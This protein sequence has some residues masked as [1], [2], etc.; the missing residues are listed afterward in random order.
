MPGMRGVK[1]TRGG[2]AFRLAGRAAVFALVGAAATVLVA[3]GCFA[4]R[5][6][7]ENARVRHIRKVWPHTT[8]AEWPP[9]PSE[10][11]VYEFPSTLVFTDTEHRGYPTM[12]F[13]RC[14]DAGWPSPGMR[15]VQWTDNASGQ[16]EGDAFNLRTGYLRPN[17]VPFLPVLPLWPGFVVD[18]AFW[19]GT[20][21][22]VWSVPG[23]VRRRVRRRRGEGG[24]CAACGYDLSGAGAAGGVCP[25]CGGGGA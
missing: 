22:L 15:A 4:V 17:S 9:F 14:F 16:F 18:T 5:L 8:P 13:M 21:F 3:W 2:L 1:R 10:A 7:W 20:A 12:Y 24:R 11:S 23:F 19:G 6:D 25:E